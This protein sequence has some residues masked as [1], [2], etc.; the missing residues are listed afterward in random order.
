MRNRDLT[1]NPKSRSNAFQQYSARGSVNLTSD[2]RSRV[3]LEA[4][5]LL[6]KSPVSIVKV[7]TSTNQT[8]V[9]ASVIRG[10]LN[11]NPELCF[12]IEESKC[13]LK[14]KNTHAINHR[15]NFQKDMFEARVNCHYGSSTMEEIMALV[16][17]GR[18][19]QNYYHYLTMS[20]MPYFSELSVR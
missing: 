2:V 9:R 5:T 16:S 18:K 13:I 3:M 10:P 12:S 8:P 1:Y 14:L 11:T 6:N 19:I 7:E 15:S 4:D 17:S 20:S